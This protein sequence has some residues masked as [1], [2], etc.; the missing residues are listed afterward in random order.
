[1]HALKALG[2]NTEAN[3]DRN[4]LTVVDTGA[5][6]ILLSNSLFDV[7]IESIRRYL[8]RHYD[9]DLLLTAR[10][11]TCLECTSDMFPVMAFRLSHEAASCSNN[12]HN[13]GNWDGETTSLRLQGSDYVRCTSEFCLTELNSHSLSLSVSIED[14]TSSIG[15]LVRLYLDQYSFGRTKRYLI[16][17]GSALDSHVKTMGSVTVAG[18]LPCCL[19]CVRTIISSPP[20]CI[21]FIVGPVHAPSFLH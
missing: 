4:V 17:L 11:C 20:I 12:Q 13:I 18:T 3:A 9:R 1:M 6:Q 19:Q 8:Q 10:G 5:S 21:S 15:N 2:S 7:T 16:Q 14:R